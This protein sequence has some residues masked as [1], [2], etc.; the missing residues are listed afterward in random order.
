MSRFLDR[1]GGVVSTFHYEEMED[2]AIVKVSQDCEAIVEHNKAMQTEDPRL[3]DWGKRIA[4]IPN[5]VVQ[6]WMQED[7]INFLTLPKKEK[8]V[9]LRRKLNSPEYRYL[10]TSGGTF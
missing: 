2:R 9:Y 8:G 10:R 7:G 1:N 4:L 3:G 6:K 5:V